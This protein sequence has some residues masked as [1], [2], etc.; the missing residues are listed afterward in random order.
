MC[1]YE[2]GQVNANFTGD[3]FRAAALGVDGSRLLTANVNNPNGQYTA[4]I[5]VQ[6]FSHSSENV[7]DE[8]H[9]NHPTFP[10]VLSE[11]CSCKSQRLNE[12]GRTEA[13]CIPDQNAPGFQAFCSGSLGVW[14]N[15]DYYGEPV[16]DTVRVL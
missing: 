16:R 12:G 4:G 8:F 11:C 15:A 9:Q 13:S 2:C 14:T 6:G 1:R 5:D 7:I 3:A 10:T